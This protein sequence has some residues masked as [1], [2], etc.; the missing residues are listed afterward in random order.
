MN[1]ALISLAMIG[2]LSACGSRTE[3]RPAPGMSEVPK[4]A[5]AA[6]PAAPS[7][8]MT[9]STQAR[10]DRKADLLI[11]SEERKDDPFDVPPGPDNG[12]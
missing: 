5:E 12:K 11:R 4:A 1:R 3:L 2:L 6:K 8:L 7:E 9:A 10:P